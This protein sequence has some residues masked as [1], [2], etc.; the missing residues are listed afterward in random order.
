[1]TRTKGSKD[2]SVH[3]K[4]NLLDKI[5]ELSE[6]TPTI[7]QRQMACQLGINRKSVVYIMKHECKIRG[8]VVSVFK[9]PLRRRTR[10]GKKADIENALQ[11]WF[12][13]MTDHGVRV[14]GPILFQESKQ[15]AL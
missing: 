8:D 10:N 9:Y 7:I 6:H 2:R 12:R 13:L 15:F 14:N 3:E 5:K 4:A 11:K 1:M